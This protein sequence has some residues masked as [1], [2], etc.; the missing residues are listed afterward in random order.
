M[1]GDSPTADAR[2]TYPGP[3][4]RSKSGGAAA[5]WPRAPLVQPGDEFKTASWLF[6]LLRHVRLVLG[7][8]LVHGY[9]HMGL[10]CSTKH[11]DDT[12]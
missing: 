1:V 4:R 11:S 2:G 8:Y 5:G 12:A 7:V 3:D 6:A 9:G 10:L